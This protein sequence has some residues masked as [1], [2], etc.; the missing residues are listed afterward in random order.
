MTVVKAAAVQLSPVLY[1]RDATVD[2]I[3]RKIDEFLSLLADRSSASYVHDKAAR[4]HS[5]TDERSHEALAVMGPSSTRVI[6]PSQLMEFV[7]FDA[8]DPRGGL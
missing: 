3:V 2:T 6:G 7:R 8:V 4:S 5:I 1:S